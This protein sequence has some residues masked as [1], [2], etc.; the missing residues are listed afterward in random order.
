MHAYCVFVPSFRYS[1]KSCV[2]VIIPYWRSKLCGVFDLFLVYIYPRHMDMH[3]VWC[4]SFAYLA[5]GQI[6]VSFRF[7]SCVGVSF[8]RMWCKK[9]LWF[10]YY[11]EILYISMISG[12]SWMLFQSFWCLWRRKY[13]ELALEQLT[14]INFMSLLCSWLLLI[15]FKVVCTS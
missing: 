8:M 4:C 12:P 11:E 5:T 3:C 7:W 2:R 10:L 6:Q 15:C 1:A 14:I 9:K 13:E